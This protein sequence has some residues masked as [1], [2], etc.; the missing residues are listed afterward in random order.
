[1][2]ASSTLTLPNFVEERG[3]GGFAQAKAGVSLYECTELISYPYLT[4]V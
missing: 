4:P 1:M 2:Y 3:G